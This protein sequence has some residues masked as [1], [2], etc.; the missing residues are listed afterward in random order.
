[1]QLPGRKHSIS[2]L[3]TRVIG[4]H[5]VRTNDE[6]AGQELNVVGPSLGVFDPNATPRGDG[7]HT[8]KF[9][10]K[11]QLEILTC[12]ARIISVKSNGQLNV[13]IGGAWFNYLLQLDLA[14]RSKQVGAPESECFATADRFDSR[15]YNRAPRT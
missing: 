14:I 3:R 10:L 6:P 7:L 11:N 13:F 2:P 9:I 8:L 12:F 15:Q 5:L 1:M 4:G